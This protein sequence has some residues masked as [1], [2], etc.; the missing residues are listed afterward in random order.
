MQ[1]RDRSKT[2]LL[3][4]TSEQMIERDP[5]VAFSHYLAGRVHVLLAL[6]DEI[7]DNLDQGFAGPSIDVGR[8]ARAESLMWLWLLGAYEVVRT[9]C[10]SKAC[11][12]QHTLDELIK[13]KKTLA[14]VRMPAAKMEK[15]GIKTPVT[16]DRSPCGLNVESRDLLMN[17]PDSQDVFARELLTELDRV[18]SSIKLSDV[19]ARHE[20]AYVSKA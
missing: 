6:A 13:L 4:P 7:I 11:F 10:Q 2:T 14:A 20:D 15:S 17:D 5:L 9:M 12:T 19:L 16:S 8:V 3:N 18:F 1:M